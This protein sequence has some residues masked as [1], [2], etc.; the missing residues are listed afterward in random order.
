[1][2]HQFLMKKKI[3]KDVGFDESKTE[4]DEVML[5]IGHIPEGDGSEHDEIMNEILNG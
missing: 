4:H 5:A 1:M 2:G 3:I